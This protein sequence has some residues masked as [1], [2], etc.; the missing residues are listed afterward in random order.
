MAM[1]LCCRW[2]AAGKL[3]AG[4]LAAGKLA[5]GKLATRQVV[6]LEGGG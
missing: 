3:A 6:I 1:R 4:K 5:A 2:R